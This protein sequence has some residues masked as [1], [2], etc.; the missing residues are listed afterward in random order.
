VYYL[1]LYA[2]VRHDLF[3]FGSI[4]IYTAEMRHEVRQSI[5]Y[6]GRKRIVACMHRSFLLAD[7][8]AQK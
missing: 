5:Q 4:M 6:S 8:R 7:N 1:Y 3:P 2:E